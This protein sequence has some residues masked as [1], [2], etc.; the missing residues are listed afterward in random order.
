MAKK[1]VTW[2]SQIVAASP[3]TNVFFFTD[4]VSKVQFLIDTGA[5]R[6]LLPKTMVRN[7]SGSSSGVKLMAANGSP[8]PTYGYKRITLSIGGRTITWKFIVAEVHL[9]IIG[10]DLLFHYALL[11]D[12]RNR[13][14]IDADSLAS[15]PITAAPSDLALHVTDCTDKYTNLLSDYPDV[16]KP[17]LRQQPHIPAKHG[18]F[19]YIKTSGP[20]V[21]ARFRRLSPFKLTAAKKVFADMESLGL[22]QKDSSPWSSPLHMVEK[23]DGSLRPCG[24]YRRLNMQTEPDHYPLPN[25]AD[26][27]SFLHGAR[28]FSKLDLLKGYFQVPMA[29]EDIPKTAITTPFGTYTFNY[30]CFGLRNAGATFQR[31]MDG[32]LGDLPF[33]VCYVDD[34]L[35]F[36]DSQ[37]EHI[38]H[39]KAVLDRLQQNGLVVRYDKCTFGVHEVD[40]LGHCISSEGVAP[41]PVKVD[42]VRHFPTPKSIK[43][44]QEFVGMVNFYHRFVPGIAAILSPLYEVLKG[45][46]KTLVWGPPQDD[47]FLAAKD[48]LAS[49]SLLTFPAPNG[50]LRLT[51]DASNIAVGAVLEQIA[52]G[53]PN[54][55]AFFSRKLS[56]S[57]SKYSTFD[58]ELLAVYLA[59]RHFKHFLEGISFTIL[60]DH[61]P[62][63]HAFCNQTDPCSSRQQRHLSAIA[64]FN[65]TFKHV[66][67]KNNPVADALSRNAISMVQMGVNLHDLARQQKQDDEY[68]AC[69]TSYTTLRWEDVPIDDSAETILCDTSTGR[70]RPWIPSPYRRRIFELVHG[71]SHPSRR[72][73][74]NLM[75]KRFVWHG[76]TKDTKCWARLCLACQQAK[77]TRHTDSGTGSFAQPQRRFGHI[78]VDIVGPLPPSGGHRYL[79][80]IVDRSTRWPEAVPMKDA[81]ADSCVAALLSHWI[82]R[83]GLPDDITS[84][85]GT[86]FT[87]QLWTSLARLLGTTAHHT[88]SYHPE[89][90]GMVE[91]LHR[92]LKASLMSRCTSSDWLYHLPWVLLGL[93]TTPKDGLDISSAEMVYGSPLQVPADFFPSGQSD[94]D[95]D[96]LRQVVDKYVPCQPTYKDR[97]KPYIPP[98]LYTSTHVFIRV[99]AHRPPLSPP[100][101]GPFKVLSRRPKAFLLDIR[102]TE[103]WVSID[104]LKP[105]YLSADDAP[106]VRLSRAGRP[107]RSRNFSP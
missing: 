102:G 8:I 96:H 23:K 50:V 29:P 94:D 68:Q 44:L 83:F 45:K 71:L 9:P 37:Q 78:H 24:D 98:D 84:D 11:V 93:R 34:I 30:S 6:S 92:T 13:R 49:A 28:I 82:S 18:I 81:T 27:T 41:L 69:R 32:I 80:T 107:L 31:L 1:R 100:Y 16:F 19:H 53:R 75:K 38:L 61:M 97:S 55:I 46:P 35:I 105:A 70:P 106:T 2:L 103:D 64:E 4:H 7:S 39:L 48:A 3:D 12:V 26:V 40:F 104:R 62:L 86:P 65:C 88:T 60:T 89:S 76:I 56:K 47:A 74:V 91:R 67:G 22:C 5:C 21:F 72:A 90:N 54:P 36:S 15:T 87:S 51:T 101:T 10:A 73:T 52:E 59:V 66:S 77:V 63:V 95:L 17:E 25:I 57:E 14:L 33:C 79:F 43:S 42:A 99:D 85:R 20:P 58:R